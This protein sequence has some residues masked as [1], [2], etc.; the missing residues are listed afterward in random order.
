MKK[1]NEISLQGKVNILRTVYIS[2]KKQLFEKIDT[3]KRRT[4]TENRK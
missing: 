2:G 1:H 4:S 3:I